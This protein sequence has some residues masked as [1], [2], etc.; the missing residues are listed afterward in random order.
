[1]PTKEVGLE[2][3][4]PGMFCKAH[5]KLSDRQTLAIQPGEDGSKMVFCLWCLRDF[6]DAMI[7]QVGAEE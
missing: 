4:E 7:G 5:G 3:V 1:M 2:I 6:L